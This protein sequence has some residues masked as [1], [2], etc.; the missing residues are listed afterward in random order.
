[1]FFLPNEFSSRKQP[2]K[3]PF[4]SDQFNCTRE[5]KQIVAMH[6]QDDCTVQSSNDGNGGSSS[7]ATL[8][9]KNLLI[10]P[11]PMH[12]ERAIRSSRSA[13]LFKKTSAYSMAGSSRFCFLSTIVPLVKKTRLAAVDVAGMQSS[14]R[15]SLAVAQTDGSVLSTHCNASDFSGVDFSRKYNW[16]LWSTLSF[17]SPDS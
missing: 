6:A 14:A 5:S 1:M 4:S 16:T 11:W 10:I 7:S 15:A 13:F 9:L 8:A 2:N 17:V 3:P 12:R